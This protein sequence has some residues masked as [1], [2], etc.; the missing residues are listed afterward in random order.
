MFDLTP[1]EAHVSAIQKTI[2]NVGRAN[3]YEKLRLHGNFTRRGTYVVR[4]GEGHRTAILATVLL[5]LVPAV[6]LLGSTSRIFSLSTAQVLLDDNSGDCTWDQVRDSDLRSFTSVTW[7]ALHGEVT[8]TE[9]EQ[10]LCSCEHGSAA[11]LSWTWVYLGH[12]PGNPIRGRVVLI[13]KLI[14]ACSLESLM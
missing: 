8:N 10:M 5:V 14:A 4:V 6:P 12:D 13:F 9:V 7:V 2:R 11:M 1:A 3:L